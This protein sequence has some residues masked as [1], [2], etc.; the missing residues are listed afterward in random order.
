MPNSLSK[1]ASSKGTPAGP[2]TAKKVWWGINLFMDH[3]LTSQGGA[4]KE[5]FDSYP[6]A[7][8]EEAN[9]KELVC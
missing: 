6:D 3:F 9:R 1:P 2:F 4:S 8:S 7:C 5:Y